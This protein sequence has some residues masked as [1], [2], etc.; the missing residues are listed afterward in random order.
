MDFNIYEKKWQN[1]WR[2]NKY[3]EAKSNSDKEKYYILVEFP[4][5]SGA[6]LHVG[7]VKSYSALDAMA[8]AKRMQGYNVLFPMGW[9]AF[10]LPA[11]QYAIKNK[12]HPADAVKENVNVFKAQL[13]KVGL[14]FD[15]SR[16]FAT[17]DPEYYKWTQWQFLKFFE[18]NMAYKGK[19]EINW[20]NTCKIGLSNEESEG[21][22]CERC[23][24]SVVKKEKEQ[25]ILKMSEYSEKLLDGLD[26]TDFADRI[27]TA[28]INWIGKSTGS[29]VDF[30]IDGTS[31]YLKVFT[32]RADTLYGATFMVLSPEHPYVEKYNDKIKN[33]DEV[34]IYKEDTKKKTEI[35][36]T[37][38]TREKTGVKLD[39]L[40]AINPVNGEKIEIW[41]ADYVLNNYGTGAIMAVP[42][43][44]DRDYEFAK[45]YNIPII[46]VLEEETGNPHDD[47][48]FKES[49][50]AV[51]YDP[52]KD[53]YLTLNW[54][55][56]GG[57]LFIGGTRKDGE[58]AKDCAIREIEEETGY[59]DLKFIKETFKIKHHYYAFN[60]D[61]YFG[62][63][64]TGVYFELISDQQNNQN[65]E[66][67]EKF[68]L[69]WVSK[70]KIEKEVKDQLHFKTFEYSI[71]DLAMTGDGIHINSDVLNGL[72][73]EDAIN[74]MNDYLE[75][76]KIGK[77]KTNYKLQDWVFSRQRF[78]GE[79]IPIIHCEDCGTVPVPETDLPV[80][81]PSVTSYEP[82]DTGESPLANIDEWVNVSCPKCGKPAKRE[83]D[84][85]PNWAGSSWY[86][87]R[88]MDPK[89]DKEFVSPEA[90]KYWNKVDYYNGGMEHATRHLLYARFW[91]NF[92]YDIGLVPFKEPFNKRVAHGMILGA[93]N[94]KMSK[95]K[96]N[97]INP[98]DM[99]K[100]Y[101]ADALR[102]YE[103]FIGDYEKD[104]AWSDNG[105]KGCKRFLDK[106]TRL[107][108]K[109]TD[110]NEYT[111]K[112]IT[113]IHKTIKKVTNDLMNM[114]YNT[115]VS[116]L[117]ILTNEY[118]SH[119]SISKKDFEVLITL[120]NPIAPH[121]T[122]ELNE[123]IG[124]EFHLASISWP[125]YDEAKTVDDE[126]EIGVQVNG[127]LR[128][129]IKISSEAKEE[130]ILKIAFSDANVIKHTE[131]K[132]IIKKIVIPGKIVNIVVK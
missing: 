122:E 60:K 11:E 20:C 77:K 63:E 132:E 87:L 105:L 25:W 128:S 101:G 8:R 50:V 42:A 28:Q 61:K 45:K 36:R 68:D 65:L 52:S 88:Y 48:S 29:E 69:E 44:D 114:K 66:D 57:R 108:E 10:G 76:K 97:V 14:S 27:K 26:D 2:D 106:V 81:L 107:K 13:E 33:I 124:N 78:W 19:K 59:V 24:S 49:I 64:S 93:N 80:V 130:E 70:E 23:G 115:A 4:Y 12:I 129:S 131:G 7:H 72:N 95:S 55:E 104:A 40:F 125:I 102:C 73:K 100:L 41:I 1:I 103:L 56:N 43:H 94:E 39:G 46:Q 89:N 35:E 62:I 98:D 84:T 96:G 127:K 18:H 54:G 109:V 16:E 5:P 32:T 119:D 79:P 3:F 86:Y 58:S 75:N 34:N 92:L 21:N 110:N 91:H 51:I 82:T 15:W 111:D 121:L 126:K 74:K 83:T 112:Y 85:M 47:E 123:L 53:K 6:G 30:L 22:I 118:D 67:D 99:I 38:A 17:T 31:D 120:L 37:D 116:S 113:V 9:D 71:A 117:M 90:L